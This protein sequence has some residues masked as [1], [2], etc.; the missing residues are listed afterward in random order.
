M[1]LEKLRMNETDCRVNLRKLVKF[2]QM[3][4]IFKSLQNRVSWGQPEYNNKHVVIR[5]E[6]WNVTLTVQI[7]GKMWG[8]K[9]NWGSIGLI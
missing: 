2:W 8:I 3:W 5:S 9:A 6:K 4:F 7:L 1:A